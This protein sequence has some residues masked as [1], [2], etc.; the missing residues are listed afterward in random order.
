MKTFTLKSVFVSCIIILVFPLSG[1]S[2]QLIDSHQDKFTKDYF[3]TAAFYPNH[4]YRKNAVHYKS[5]I[6][7]SVNNNIYFSWTR[8]LSFAGNTYVGDKLLIL[9]SNNTTLTLLASED[10]VAAYHKESDQTVQNTT[11]YNSG[12]LTP[13]TSTSTATNVQGNWWYEGVGKYT[14][15]Y[16]DL[17]LLASFQTISVRAYCGKKDYF[18]PYD[19]DKDYN[20]FNNLKI[21]A[22]KFKNEFDKRKIKN[23]F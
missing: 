13:A 5:W 16:A 11:Y 17:Q 15:S 19:Y 2:Q 6:I 22:N 12:F 21:L 18:D 3:I 1:R 8:N 23:N 10:N 7:T 14:L 4:D 20:P 9:L